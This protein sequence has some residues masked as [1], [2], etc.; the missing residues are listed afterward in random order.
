VVV[1]IDNVDAARP[2]TGIQYADVVYEEEVEGGLSRLA[3]VFQSNYPSQVGPVRSGRLTDEGIADDLNRPV[4]AFSGANGLFL[5]ILSGQPVTLVDDDNYPDDFVRI[6]DNIPHNLYTD[7]ATLAGLAASPA[8][9]QPL[10]TYVPAGRS[11]G[12]SGVTP[13]AGMSLS[14]PAASVTWTWSPSLGRWTRTQNGTPDVVVGGQQLSATNVVVYFVDYVSSGLA[15]G[16]GAPPTEIPEGILT[17][18]GPVWVFSAGQVVKGTWSRPSLTT[19]A[20]YTDAAGQPIALTPGNTWVELAPT[21]T[22]VT[23]DP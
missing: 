7:V 16:E 13:A 12:G 23:I 9:P 20:S 15:T 17:G 1:K 14:F 22:P 10:F 8:A 4:L 18:S 11:F 19:P 5:P 6:G 2:Q 21:G 3:A